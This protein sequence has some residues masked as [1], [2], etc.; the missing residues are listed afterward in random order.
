MANA[1]EVIEFPVFLYRESGPDAE[2]RPGK[3]PDGKY[4]LLFA[5]M[6]A[7]QCLVFRALLFL[8]VCAYADF[9]E[10]L[11]GW[12]R[13]WRLGSAMMAWLMAGA[14]WGLSI[15]LIAFIGLSHA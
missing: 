1:A 5:S 4:G 9:R 3:K 10:Y 13:S 12:M 2:P 15:G 14:S 11:N 6:W 7:S 8:M